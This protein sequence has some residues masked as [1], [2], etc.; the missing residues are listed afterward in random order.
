LLV[1]R[2]RRAAKDPNEIPKAKLIWKKKKFFFEMPSHE[3]KQEIPA[4][5]KWL[6]TAY[7]Q[8]KQTPKKGEDCAHKLYAFNRCMRRS[9]GWTIE[10]LN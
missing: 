7:K 4:H 1:C 5:C 3:A 2:E 9:V 10:C 8:C 6:W